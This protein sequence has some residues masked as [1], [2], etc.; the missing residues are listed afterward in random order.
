MLIFL[1][2]P[3]FLT[4]SYA[5]SEYDLKL[6][7]N[8]EITW[9]YSKVDEDLIE[10]IN[11][12]F[13]SSLVCISDP[14]TEKDMTIM[15]SI[16]KVE[17]LANKWKI[18]I[19]YKSDDASKIKSKELTIYKNPSKISNEWVYELNDLRL[20][21]LPVDVD[22]YLNEFIEDFPSISNISIKKGSFSQILITRS[23]DNESVVCE[24]T[25]DNLGIMDKFKLKIDDETA[26]EY[27][28]I[29]VRKN[30]LDFIPLIIIIIFTT[31]IIAIIPVSIFA[32]TK[33]NFSKNKPSVQPNEK[34]SNDNSI[35]NG[36]YK[37]INDS[38]KEPILLSISENPYIITTGNNSR[39]IYEKYEFFEKDDIFNE[40]PD[41]KYDSYFKHH[42]TITSN[43]PLCGARR[44]K[45]GKY[46]YYCG[47]KFE[48]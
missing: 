3:V 45:E 41:E 37:G 23:I 35:Q 30:N 6:E 9:R 22:N 19:S 18:Q 10:R 14:D 5:N 24:I 4:Q 48:E 38:K 34:H 40:Y 11:T 29:E 26:L 31:V 25:Y 46:C 13:N 1:L 44:A 21:Y 32:F 47:N 43:C 39:A 2:S 27:M 36:G 15:H 8:Y 12:A 33:R 17:E 28:K 7:N 16:E 42:S 20:R